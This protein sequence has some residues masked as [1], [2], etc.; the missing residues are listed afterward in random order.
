MLIIRSL[1]L[2]F[3]HPFAH[4]VNGLLACSL[5]HVFPDFFIHCSMHSY[6]YLCLHAFFC[7]FMHLFH[8]VSLLRVRYVQP[9]VAP[10]LV[11]T[12]SIPC[13]QS[14]NILCSTDPDRHTPD[15]SLEGLC[16]GGKIYRCE[17]RGVLNQGSASNLH[18]LQSII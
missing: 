18:I 14:G 1:I 15:V 16:H 13:K 4:S 12:A 8:S 9:R 7:P 6:T 17:W 2:L 11:L 3:I 10:G 5:T